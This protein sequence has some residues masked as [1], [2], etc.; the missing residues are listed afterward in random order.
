MCYVSVIK[1]KK[2]RSV[3]VLTL[4]CS[5]HFFHHSRALLALMTILAQSFLTLVGSHLVTLL[6]LSVWHNFNFL[7]IIDSLYFLTSL[8]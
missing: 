1:N 8:I 7:L 4:T 6:F 5:S 2:T 3:K